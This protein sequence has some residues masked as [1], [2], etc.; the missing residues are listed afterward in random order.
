MES[1]SDADVLIKAMVIDV[2]EARLEQAKSIYIAS[3][4]GMSKHHRW[5]PLDHIDFG[6]FTAGYLVG[7]LLEAFWENVH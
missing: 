2:N 5:F 7:A 3:S 1:P 6:Y 4:G